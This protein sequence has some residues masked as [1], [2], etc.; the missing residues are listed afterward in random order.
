MDPLDLLPETALRE[1]GA[2][3][4]RFLDLG[5]MTFR[6]ACSWVRDVPY[7]ANRGGRH[8][9]V[10]FD[11]MR[12]TCQ[13]KHDL[14]AALAQELD[15]PVSKYVGGYRLDES[16]IEGAGAVL[17]AHGVAYVPETH[18]VLKYDERFFDLTAGNRH[19]KRKDI[20]DMDVYVRVHPFAPK[21]IEQATYELCAQYYRGADPI[22]GLK[23]VNELR[24]IAMECRARNRVVCLHE[25]VGAGFSR[26]EAL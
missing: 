20:T 7:G 22:L 15:L 25:Y 13:S 24:R 23:S 9:D 5:V 8:A 16:I 21:R 18:C 26:P 14:I 11:E 19:G 17:A 10:V 3:G 1:P 4:R 6:A 2:I 12:G